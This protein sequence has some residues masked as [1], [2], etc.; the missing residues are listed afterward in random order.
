VQFQTW[1]TC[2]VCGRVVPRSD[3]RH[4]LDQ[5]HRNYPWE[6]DMRVVRCPEHWSE[7][8]L[9]HTVEGRTKKNRAAM[10]KALAEPV[11]TMPPY[12]GPF[13]TMERTD[14]L[15]KTAMRT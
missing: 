14:P 10:R 9:R 1:L 11:P 3:S 2:Q 5:P 13:P 6:P 4:W 15:M 12:L 8:A 7:W